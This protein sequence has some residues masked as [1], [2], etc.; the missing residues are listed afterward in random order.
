M[1][2]RLKNLFHYYFTQMPKR[3]FTGPGRKL[4]SKRPKYGIMQ[5]A[6]NFAGAAMRGATNLWRV[7]QQAKAAISTG[8]RLRQGGSRSKTITVNKNKGKSVKIKPPQDGESK[9]L[10]LYK[11][12]PTKNFRTIKSITNTCTTEY[13]DSGKRTSGSMGV[14]GVNHLAGRVAELAAGSAPT[15]RAGNGAMLTGGTDSDVAQLM[16]RTLQYY[17]RVAAASVTTAPFQNNFRDQKFLLESATYEWHITNTSQVEFKLIIYDLLARNSNVTFK[18]P[19]TDWA[20]GLTDAQ[21]GTTEGLTAS[22]GTSRP[23]SKPTL[24]KEFNVNWK[25]IRVTE[26]SLSPG[27]IHEH[28]FHMKINRVVDWNHW[29]KYQQVGGFTYFPMI[30][31]QGQPVGTNN[32]AN[33]VSLGYH[34]MGFCSTIRL[35]GRAVTIFPRQIWQSNNLLTSAAGLTASVMNDDTEVPQNYVTAGTFVGNAS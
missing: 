20:T 9:S 5:T 16:A 4:G 15:N 6:G 8:R 35:R 30:V 27:R 3:K 1:L 21:G 33:P 29:D 34:E 2:H 13:T 12:K 25:I 22:V 11:K 31:T 14:Q 32:A 18:N 17:N 28:K 19:I 23:N 26:L 24:S 7:G 10:S